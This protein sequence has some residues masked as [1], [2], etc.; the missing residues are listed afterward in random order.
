MVLKELD[1]DAMTHSG[2][3]WGWSWKKFA[4]YKMVDN[5]AKN[6]WIGL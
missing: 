3:R 5:F 1:F 4:V 6:S 2:T